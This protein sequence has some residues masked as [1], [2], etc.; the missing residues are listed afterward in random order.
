MVNNYFTPS[1][2]S[3]IFGEPVFEDFDSLFSEPNEQ[4]SSGIDPRFI[5]TTDTPLVQL[6]EYAAKRWLESN[7]IMLAIEQLLSIDFESYD[8]NIIKSILSRA[9][10]AGKWVHYSFNTEKVSYYDTPLESDYGLIFDTETFVAKGG[11]PIIATAIGASGIYIYIDKAFNGSEYIPSYINL[12]NSERLIVAHNVGFDYQLITQRFQ[13]N[14]P[15]SALCTMA[16]GK[17]LFGIDTAN[18]WRLTATSKNDVISQ[19]VQTELACSLSLT[20]L[21]QFVT[22]KPLPEKLKE[23]RNIFVEAES[24]KEFTINKTNLFSY[25]LNDVILLLE[26]FQTVYP[27]FEQWLK[28]PVCL[29]GLIQ[30]AD[31]LLPAARD[32]EPWLEKN[33]RAAEQVN[34][35]VFKLV[36]PYLEQLHEDWLSGWLNPEKH[37]QLSQVDFKL[38]KPKGWRKKSLPLGFPT[39]AK[40]Y[41]QFMAQQM[42]LS[43]KDLTYLLQINWK[44]EPII[45]SKKEGWQT[46]SGF[47]LPHPSGDASANLGEILSAACMPYVEQ[48][49]LTSALLEKEEL[50][51]LY[52]LLDS[53]SLVTSYGERIKAMKF[54][55]IKAK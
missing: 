7:K 39:I 12:G 30:S 38:V 36:L 22:K 5:P 54:N 34:F 52:R 17:A 55:D 53:A 35:E 27:M 40:W 16:M 20:S 43:G 19:R 9:A 23:T 8:F 33:F 25:A 29:Q 6:T 26:L 47:K 48:D 45:K 31:A 51:K 3:A 32:F 21:Y 49:L 15:V 41:Y 11:Y 24:F 14:N 10:I 37:V 46:I 44:D 2:V 4:E 28:S 1:E 13:F 42:S 18:R 50:L